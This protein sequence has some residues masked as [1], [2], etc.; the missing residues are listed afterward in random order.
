HPQAGV[1]MARRNIEIFHFDAVVFHANERE[2][3]R[4]PVGIGDDALL[5]GTHRAD[6]ECS[7]GIDGSGSV[8][9]SI[10]HLHLGIARE[11]SQLNLR[12]SSEYRRITRAFDDGHTAD[13][14]ASAQFDLKPCH[15][16]ADDLKIDL[17]GVKIALLEIG[18]T[19]LV[20]VWR[21]SL[22]TKLPR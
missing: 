1:L 14:S 3:L 12:Q 16:A 20:I 10:P 9:Q 22:E 13:R 4:S 19:D 17:I 5:A 7:I 21:E 8:E 2:F 18:H 11:N 6:F 15:I